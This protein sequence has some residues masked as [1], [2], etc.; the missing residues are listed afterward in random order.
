MGSHETFWDIAGEFLVEPDIEQSTMFG[1]A[2]IR[3]DGEFVAMPGKSFGGMVVKLPEDDVDELIAS[4]AGRSVA[5]G[6]RTFR[7]WVGVDD[8]ARW[9]DLIEGSIAF[10][11][12]RD[13][14]DPS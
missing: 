11:R 8:E 12:T 7:E 1:F 13:D 10:A 6:G 9:R 14:P 4:G 3:A 2:C 5:P